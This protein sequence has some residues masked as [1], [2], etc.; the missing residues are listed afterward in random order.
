[1]KTFI[2]TLTFIEKYEK[3]VD[4]LSIIKELVDK[5]YKNIEIRREFLTNFDEEL[6]E[7]ADIA[8]ENGVTLY[9][10]IPD[11]LYKDFKLDKISLSKYAKEV[12]T[13]GAKTIKLSVGAYSGYNQG[14]DIF[15]KEILNSKIKLYVENDQT[16]ENGRLDKIKRFLSDCKTYNNDVKATFDI[17]NWLW[18][19]ESPEKC[20]IEL[21]EYVDYVHFKDV[22]I[23]NGKYEAAK[24]GEGIVDWKYFK[25][26]FKDISIGLEYPCGKNPI[27]VIE[28][29]VDK[30]I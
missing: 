17:G 27:D 25:E 15:L 23:E 21:K 14:D 24:L 6:K 11:T 12:E 18:A 20:A 9:Y 1:M 3:T 13:L 28:K 10:S 22:K 7:I 30:L 2:N 16:F 5:G 8:N 4:Q 19:G 26:L 29:E